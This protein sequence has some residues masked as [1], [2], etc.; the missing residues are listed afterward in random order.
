MDSSIVALIFS[1]A[2]SFAANAAQ[3]DCQREV[4]HGNF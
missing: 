3:P 1:G 4:S 2:S